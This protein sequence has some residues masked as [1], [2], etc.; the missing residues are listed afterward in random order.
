M[1]DDQGKIWKAAKIRKAEMED[2][3]DPEGGKI[4]FLAENFL[5]IYMGISGIVRHFSRFKKF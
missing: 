5:F 1:D 3:E 4:N 2:L